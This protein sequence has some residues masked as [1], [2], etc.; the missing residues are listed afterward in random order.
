MLK[1]ID[2]ETIKKQSKISQIKMQIAKLDKKLKEYD[3][4]G[5][6]IAT[7][8]GTVEE[9]ATQIAQMDIWAKQIDKLEEELKQIK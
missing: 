1:Y 3:Y 6:K 8:R 4:I 9:Y 5:T 2:K 7:G